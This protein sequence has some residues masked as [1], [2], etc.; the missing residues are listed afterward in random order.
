MSI[1]NLDDNNCINHINGAMVSVLV[2]SVV[3]GGFNLG[4]VQTM[5]LRYARSIK[6]QEQ[7]LV[8]WESW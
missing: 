6:V 3:D 4:S 7:I 8:D 2:S 1:W 5:L